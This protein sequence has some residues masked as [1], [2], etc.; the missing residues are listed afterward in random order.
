MERFHTL[1]GLYIAFPLSWA[2]ATLI[3]GISIIIIYGKIKRRFLAE[4]ASD[5]DKAH[6]EEE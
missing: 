1:S 4:N 6:A 2:I 3:M 5:G